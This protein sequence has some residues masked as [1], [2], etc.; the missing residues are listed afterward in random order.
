MMFNADKSTIYVCCGDSNQL[1]IVDRASG[2]LLLSE[3]LQHGQRIDG[4]LVVNPYL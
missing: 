2:K 1:G 3:D 4:L